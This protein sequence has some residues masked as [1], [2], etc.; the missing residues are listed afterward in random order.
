MVQCQ[1]IHASTLEAVDG[2]FRR[3]YDGF[4]LIEAGIENDRNSRL[5]VER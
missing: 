3:A 2:L 1:H 4:I 5:A